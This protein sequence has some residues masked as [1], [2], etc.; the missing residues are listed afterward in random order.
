[1]NDVFWYTPSTVGDGS[2]LEVIETAALIVE[3]YRRYS[4]IQSEGE[5]T[6][7]E[8]AVGDEQLVVMDLI[9]VRVVGLAEADVTRGA[10]TLTL[11]TDSTGRGIGAVTLIT[12]RVEDS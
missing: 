4:C 1:M 7:G 9:L 5:L 2:E 11:P 10:L 3:G 12:L 8:E 6:V